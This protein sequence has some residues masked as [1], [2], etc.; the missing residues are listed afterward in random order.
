[1][2][3]SPLTRARRSI[4]R[5]LTCR[6]EPPEEGLALALVLGDRSALDPALRERF[7]RSGTA[8]LLAISGL[9]VGIVALLCGSIVRRLASRVPRLRERFSPLACGL[10]AGTA[11]ALAYGSLTGWS[12]STRRAAAMCAVV[13]VALATRRRVDALQ[14]LCVAWC[15]LLLVDPAALWHPGTALSFGSVLALLRLVPRARRSTA[16]ALLAPAAAT[17]GTG[18][19]ALGTFG[20]LPL[21]AI[22]ANLLAIPVLGGVAVPLLL[23]ASA[24]GLLSGV[25]GTALLAAAEASLRVG[26]A[27]V[28]LAGDP[29]WSPVLSASPPP[30]LALAGQLL[31]LGALALPRPGQRWLGA[32]SAV[33]LTAAPWHPGAP[34]AGELSLTA[35][36]VGHGDCLLLGLPSGDPILI[37][38]GGFPGDFDPGERWVVPALH[39]LGVRRLRAAAV[40]HLHV[41]HYG[42]MAAVLRA[43]P[44]QALW[45]PVEVPQQHG[46][47]DLLGAAHTAGA[48]I[49]VLAAGGQDM[50]DVGG[51]Q[52]AV[53]HPRDGRA[54]ADG[55]RR[56]AA[57]DHSMVLR[58]T[59]GQVSFLLTGDAEASL[60]R[61]L[62]QDAAPLRS[63]LIKV[64]HHGSDTSSRPAFT[65]A[66]GPVLAIASL[67]P[68]SRHGL[69]RPSVVHRYRSQGAIWLATGTHGTVQASTDG[70]RLRFRCF[71]QG[72]GWTRW[73]DLLPPPPAS[74]S[75]D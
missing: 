5:F 60:E 70:R 35:L 72:S 49:R 38:A 51:V 65:T 3:P 20:Q 24:I 59:L 69:P 62:L 32:I 25:A 6:L 37:D 63:Q 42:G 55:S 44:T 19:V 23:A 43:F 34:P 74:G 71:R 64:P 75:D 41:D 26:C 66:V 36:S 61:R 4:R 53:L 16:A 40:S 58:A 50:G 46:A 1:V 14:V 18:P 45:L 28:D 33:A 17:V 13:A 31:L 73:T 21:V 12:I 9:H 30:G 57:N 52:L 22:G 29:R 11:A 54:C 2:A 15:G 48:E 8:H 7:S 67:D 56:C 39:R 10:L 27:V 47:R 68:R